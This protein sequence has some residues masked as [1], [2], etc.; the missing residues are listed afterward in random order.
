MLESKYEG[1]I[2]IRRDILQVAILDDDKHVVTES[3]VR[4]MLYDYKNIVREL[5]S[6]VVYE[7]LQGK[8]TK[9][10]LVSDFLY[11][12]NNYKG[13]RISNILAQTV[14]NVF[15]KFDI[16]KTI[17]QAVGYDINLQVNDF[18]SWQD[19]Q[20]ENKPKSEFDN[21]LTKAIFNKE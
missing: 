4:G 2:T 14:I 7:N 5:P 8:S 18:I 11:I 6:I 17:E 21:S 12:C 3:S 13:R 20:K 10:Y 9:G 19:A 1:N 15:E 16:T